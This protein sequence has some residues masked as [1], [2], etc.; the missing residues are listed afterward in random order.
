MLKDA[1]SSA[2][3]GSQAAIGVILIETKKGKA[4]AMKFNFYS[5]VGL[6]EATMLPEMVP[7]WIY[8]ESHNEASENMGYYPICTDEDIEKYRS[9]TDPDYPNDNHMEHVWNSGKGMVSK[10]GLSMS[11]GT[12]ATQFMFSASY[13]DKKGIILNNDMQDYNMRLNL[14]SKL[15][16]HLKLTTNISA[17]QIN[18]RQSLIDRI[19]RG[20]LRLNNT[21]IGV[22]DDGYCGHIETTTIADLHGPSFYSD[23][24]F[25]LFGTGELEWEFFKGFILSC[26]L[27]YTDNFYESKDF[28]GDFVFPHSFILHPMIWYRHGRKS[29]ITTFLVCWGALNKWH[30]VPGL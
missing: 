7:S 25:Y 6:Q 2:I 22:R 24:R 14:S 11:G 5:H 10:Y 19:T 3:Y 4:G 9:G 16:D 8:P 15:S 27:G 29:W 23:D 12:D 21:I 28:L 18:G 30:L 20:A 13:L 17:N 1:A 26:R